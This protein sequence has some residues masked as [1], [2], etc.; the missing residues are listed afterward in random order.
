MVV[1]HQLS[2]TV[3]RMSKMP[4]DEVEDADLNSAVKELERVKSELVDE[5]YDFD[6]LENLIEL[7]NILRHIEQNIIEK[8]ATE[9][10]YES[11]NMYE[12]NRIN[13][14]AR[15]KHKV[16]DLEDKLQGE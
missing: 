10:N 11:I 6:T 9:S 5:N 3:E 12:I 15:V 13:E 16:E 14:I 8:L 7:R 4:I 2:A 1:L